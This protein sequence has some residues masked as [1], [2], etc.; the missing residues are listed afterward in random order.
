MGG[1]GDARREMNVEPNVVVAAGR[2]LTGVETHPHMDH[3]GLRRLHR[4]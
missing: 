4:G 2:T 1:G 3:V